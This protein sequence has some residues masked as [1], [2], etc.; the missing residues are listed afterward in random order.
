MRSV[1]DRCVRRAWLVAGSEAGQLINEL[2]ERASEEIVTCRCQEVDCFIERPEQQQ[3]IAALMR[4]VARKIVGDLGATSRR[5]LVVRK[6]GYER[7]STPV[8]ASNSCPA[9]GSPTPDRE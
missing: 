7:P 6:T 9:W 5:Q 2:G 1:G 8:C 3:S 4:E